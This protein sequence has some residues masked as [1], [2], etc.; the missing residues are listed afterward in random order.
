MAT[1]EELLATELADDILTID[2]ETRKI[3]IPPSIRNLGVEYD[4]EVKQLYFSVPRYYDNVDLSEFSV[5]INYLNA[6]AESG[7]YEPKD[8][9]TDGETINFSWIVGRHAAAYKGDV[10][11]IVCMKKIRSIDS[12]IEKEFNTT[13]SSLPVLEGLETDEAIIAE[14]ADILDEWKTDL[15][16]MGDT[17]EQRIKDAGESILSSLPED[18]ITMTD[19]I[20][21]AIHTR[22]NAIT[23][24]IEGDN[25][26]IIDDASNDYLRGLHLYGKTY[27]NGEPS[28]DNQIPLIDR[29]YPN[30]D[31]LFGTDFQEYDEGMKITSVKS[32][33][34]IPVDSEGIYVDS[35][36]QHWIS[37]EI[38]F[39]R[40]KFIQ[41][42]H[43]LA[44]D[45]ER[46][47][48][49]KY[50]PDG[51]DWPEG[52]YILQL[53][54]DV[55]EFGET[56]GILCSFLPTRTKNDLVEGKCTNGI[57]ID[58][59]GNILVKFGE[60]VNTT[61]LARTAYQ[62]AINSKGTIYVVLDTPYEK[63][64][65]DDEIQTY[66][67]MHTRYPRTVIH[68]QCGGGLKVTYNAD[69]QLYFDNHRGATD[70]QVQTS[71][72]K[73]MEEHP[74]TGDTVRYRDTIVEVSDFVA[75]DTYT[76]Y[77]YKAT[78]EIDE[79]TSDSVVSIT[80]SLNDATSGNFAPICESGDGCVYIYTKAIPES[81]VTIPLI[82]VIKI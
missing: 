45:A 54:S 57:C 49:V 48:I 73:Y 40:G 27:Q 36:G 74:Y 15:F 24:T 79:I 34:G 77:P 44:T 75:D 70:E 76:D 35:N 30:I 53:N 20:D 28:P 64:L 62:T 56:N 60:N 68:S 71:V 82:E 69:T 46:D 78:L 17:V 8:V 14:Y 31:I 58:E 72:N 21:E 39:E 25:S 10:N 66:K 22:A 43:S 9:A 47:T 26:I 61:A 80:F 18:Y 55:E 7:M 16:G 6:N 63:S 59:L 52:L 13:V 32:L 41:R 50:A 37:D 4:D 29:T 2:L 81:D 33:S 3:S 67:R 23:V 42:I 65:S 12:I 11:F 19:M 1:V 51:T 5:R 38:D